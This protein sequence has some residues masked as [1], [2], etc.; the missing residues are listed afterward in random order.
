ML[1][2]C[3]A[4]TLVSDHAQLPNMNDATYIK[5]GSAVL[6]TE[7]SALAALV[8]RLD[9]QFAQACR[10]M[11][12]C[13]G[14]VVVTGV[15]KSGHVCRK[16]AATLASVGTPAFF[17][18]AGEA[19]HGDLGMLLPGDTVLA[20]SN[21]GTTQELLAILPAI[22]RLGLPLIALTGRPDSKL[23]RMAD[24]NLDVSVDD[25]AC[26]LG[27]APTASTTV[28]MAMGDALAVTLLEARGFGPEDF[29]R[30][31]P[32]GRLG[33]R[34]LLHISD[35]MHTDTDIPRVSPDTLLREALVEISQKRLGITGVVDSEDRVIG[36]FTDGD[37]RRSLDQQVDIHQAS[38]DQLMTPNCV[39]IQADC[40]AAEALKL[41]EERKINA[42]LVVD[43]E[44]RLVGALNMHDL[45]RA[46]VL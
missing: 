11:L 32:G 2:A 26:S 13:K 28:A 10:E 12:A 45:L 22:K 35:I 42:L 18:H 39:T 8:Q 40:L 37:L 20:I 15:G 1:A 34:L 4:G 5:L 29:A 25:E 27:L 41:M 14:R 44:K 38:M 7:A 3:E 17:V 33:R 30:A 24:I 19:S 43:D 31:H 16:I 36:I 9:G 21:S 6:Q 46:G 23:A